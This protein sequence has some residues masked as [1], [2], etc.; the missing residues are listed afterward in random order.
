MFYDNILI[1][2]R[3]LKEIEIIESID[4]DDDWINYI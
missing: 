1:G 2:Q 3:I 4:D